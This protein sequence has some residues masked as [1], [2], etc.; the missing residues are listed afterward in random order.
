MSM[1]ARA[2]GVVRMFPFAC[3]LRDVGGATEVWQAATCSEAAGT[4]A[5]QARGASAAR[6]EPM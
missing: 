6:G 3:K 2:A 4:V 5:R 1:R